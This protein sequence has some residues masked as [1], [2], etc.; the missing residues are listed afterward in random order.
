[1]ALGSKT[2]KR[3]LLL[4]QAWASLAISDLVFE[5]ILEA[6]EDRGLNQ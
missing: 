5:L 2:A 1:M 4:A 3:H 6:T